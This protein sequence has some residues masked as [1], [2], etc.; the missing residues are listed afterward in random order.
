[1]ITSTTDATVAE[2]F[3]DLRSSDGSHHRGALPMNLLRIV[4]H[5]R[6][7]DP[8]LEDGP[9]F[10]A[11][12]MEDKW[13]VYL[14]DGCLHFSRSWTGDLTLLA[15]A[16]IDSG[17]LIVTEVA[18]DGEFVDGDGYLAI[19][20][21]DFLIKRLLYHLE[22]PHPLPRTLPP[23]PDHI[24]GHSFATYGRWG[25]FATFEDTTNLTVSRQL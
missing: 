19:R 18:A 2:R 12:E 9:L 11:A 22:V 10:V 14:Y 21:V 17:E 25:W 6:Y 15:P 7:P 4:C 16:E 5:L 13:D 24:L 3:V 1:M 23:D 20:M 8:G